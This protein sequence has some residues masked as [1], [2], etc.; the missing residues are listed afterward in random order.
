MSSTHHFDRLWHEAYNRD[1]DVLHEAARLR[2]DGVTL[3]LAE[4]FVMARTLSAGGARFRFA[5]ASADRDAAR[6]H[7][8]RRIEGFFAEAT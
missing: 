5:V 1:L 3:P 2:A 4:L 6:K 8:V 7:D